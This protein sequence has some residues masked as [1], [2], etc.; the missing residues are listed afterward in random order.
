MIVKPELN[1]VSKLD[2]LYVRML[3]MKLVKK[4]K[5][6]SFAVDDVKP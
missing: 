5:I 2:L 3:E 4:L 6:N 1:S